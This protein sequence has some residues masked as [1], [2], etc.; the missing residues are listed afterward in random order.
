MLDLD[1]I[2]NKQANEATEKEIP[3]VSLLYNSEACREL[4]A[5]AYQF[6]GFKA[7]EQL[8]YNN[9]NIQKLVEKKTKTILIELNESKNVTKDA[10][11]IS[12]IVPHDVLVVII[13]KENA[14]STIRNLKSLGFYYLFWPISKSELIDF[15]RNLSATSHLAVGL[16]GNRNAKRIAVVGT[17]GGVGC[18]LLSAEIS[19]L[20]SL[21]HKTRTL[22]VDHNYYGG[23]CD[24]MLGTNTLTKRELLLGTLSDSLDEISAKNLTSKININLDYLGLSMEKQTPAAL[25]EFSD[26]VVNLLSK[27]VNFVVEDVSASINKGHDIS[28]LCDNNDYLILLLEPSISSLRAA[29]RIHA[30][31]LDYIKTNSLNIK[32][33]I[34]LNHHREKAV[35]TISTH[36]IK[37]ILGCSIDYTLPYDVNINNLLIRGKKLFSSQNNL[38]QPLSS[39]VADILG[40]NRNNKT[41]LLKSIL[42]KLG[43]RR[44]G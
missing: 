11:H 36:E 15:V 35:N 32:V 39:M 34:V 18:S 13:G 4:V 43:K 10:K 2:L 8:K 25:G 27:S 20:L 3:N 22:L 41:S 40:V 21:K 33:I 28:W 44:G 30:Q 37:K 6:E 31:T 38:A 16:K 5:E 42:P 1:S 9:E 12:H 17:K 23:N 7:P 19:G 24:I 29:K 26:H 14:I